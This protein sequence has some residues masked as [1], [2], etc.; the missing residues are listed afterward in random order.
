M[1]QNPASSEPLVKGVA[2]LGIF[3]YL[4]TR[5]EGEALLAKVLAAL[6]PEAG[7]VC[8][9][10]V[11]AV[12]DYPYPIYVNLLRAV[13][14]VFGRGDLR[15]CRELGVFAAIRDI[16][17]VYTLF[18]RRAQPEALFR[19]GPVVWKSYYPNAGAYVTIDAHPDHS[20]I[21]IVNFPQMDPAHC[22][23][24]DGWMSQAL[25]S[26]GGRWI[27]EVHEVLC[28]SR[29]DPYHEYV[30]RWRPPAEP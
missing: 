19:D 18:K 7:Q 22:R 5:P 30:G 27:E 11:I 8:R 6:S 23:L 16:E 2:F 29:G 14:Q 4:K 21:R 17:T 24:M 1:N 9:K 26:A 13:D 15:I 20:L 10:K 28:S 12:V 3:K 25:V